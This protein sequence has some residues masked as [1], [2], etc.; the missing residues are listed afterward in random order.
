MHCLCDY[1]VSEASLTP[2]PVAL[3]LANYLVVKYKNSCII[4][5]APIELLSYVICNKGITVRY[6]ISF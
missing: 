5:V 3:T 2:N 4:W 1:E 6:R